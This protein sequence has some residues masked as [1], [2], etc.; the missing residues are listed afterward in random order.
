MIR[1]YKKRVKRGDRHA[2]YLLAGKYRDGSYQ[3]LRKS[4]E[5]VHRAA[6]LGHV[7]AIA[8]LGSMYALGLDG[9]SVD[10]T[11]GRDF[12]ERAAKSGETLALVNLGALE[13][14]KG[15]TKL[16]LTY[17]RTAAEAGEDEAVKGLWN[18]F[19]AGE[20]S[21]DDLEKSLRAHQKAN[22]DMRSEERERHK[23]WKKAQEEKKKKKKKEQGNA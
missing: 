3:D 2:M 5:L 18:W 22:E 16:G 11:K 7:G 8:E 23:R 17:L 4:R 20:L 13:A 19:K 15:R 9:I 21:K 10:E 14:R 12:L 6:D 1:R